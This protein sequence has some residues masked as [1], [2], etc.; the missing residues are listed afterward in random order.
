MGEEGEEE[1]E[2]GEEE[3]EEEEVGLAAAADFATVVGVGVVDAEGSVASPALA[4]VV[5]EAI[6][7]SLV[8]LRSHSALLFEAS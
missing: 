7:E 2:E 8:A 4:A 6:R 5:V 1:G 3:E